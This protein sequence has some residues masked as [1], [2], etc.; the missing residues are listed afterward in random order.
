MRPLV[1]TAL[2]AAVLLSACGGSTANDDGLSGPSRETGAAM[3]A[4]TRSQPGTGPPP[5]TAALISRFEMPASV[6]CDGDSDTV[7]ATYETTADTVAFLVD[8]RPVTEP[9]APVSGSYQLALPCDAA[10]HTVVLVAVSSAGQQIA[11]RAVQM[12]RAALEGPTG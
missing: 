5:P 7:T 10:T 11:T 9:P 12:R 1:L 2:S 3:T 6:S 4:T 8:Q